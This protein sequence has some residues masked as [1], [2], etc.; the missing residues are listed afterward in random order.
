MAA[1]PSFIEFATIFF[2][3]NIFGQFFLPFSSHGGGGGSR[4]RTLD[5]EK[6]W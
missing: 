5:L 2:Q 4:T 6:M 1:K 3:K